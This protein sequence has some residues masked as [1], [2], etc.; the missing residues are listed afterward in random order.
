[1][2]EEVGRARAVKRKSFANTQESDRKLHLHIKLAAR[3]SQNKNVQAL[4]ATCC[5]VVI[6]NKRSHDL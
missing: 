3:F 1:M 2:A 4:L 5:L 6:L